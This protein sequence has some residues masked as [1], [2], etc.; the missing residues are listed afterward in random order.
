[1]TPDTA[2]RI[3][4]QVVLVTGAS[5][6]IG[7]ATAAW[8]KALGGDVFGTATS[9]GGADRISQDLGDGRGLVLDVTDADAI[10]NTIRT[11]NERAGAVTVLVNNAAITRDQLLM[12]LKDED[13]DAVMNT[14][15]RGLMQVTR[16]C[17]RGMLKAR[18][19]RVVNVS[20]VVGYSGNPG[21]SNY[22]A[23]KAGVAG[24]TRSLA[25]EVGSR[26][27]TANVVAPGFID[28]DMTRELD[29]GQRQRLT[30]GIP[31]GR[32]GTV[33]DVAAAIGFLAGPAGSYLTG[34]TL[35]VNGGMYMT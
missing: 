9:Q 15:L 6:G 5:R 23:A 17:L 20:S 27:I 24:F 4:D 13:W 29:E 28:T 21:Q 32:L 14:N 11:I 26:G 34:Q 33:E 35:H 19:G 18:A 31:L 22:A 10:Q 7:Q 3:D 16:A 12:R 30:D 25:H 1:M 2:N 8:L